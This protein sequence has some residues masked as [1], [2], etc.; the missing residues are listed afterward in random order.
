L[1]GTL[2]VLQVE[3][4]E[5]DAELIVR[6]LRR[7]GYAPEAH[8]IDTPHDLRRSLAERGW[9]LVISDYVMPSFTAL[10]ALAIV[11]ASS[12]DLPFL[13]VSGTIGEETA[14][15]ALRAGAHDFLVKGRL[16][17][18]TPAVERE[19]REAEN[20]RRKRQAEAARQASEARLRALMDA[21]AD[22]VI[23]A[24]ALGQVVETNPAAERMF[25]FS[26]EEIHGR[27]AAMLLAERLRPIYL[28]EIAGAAEGSDPRTLWQAREAVGLKRDGREFPV[29]ISLS[30]WSAGG[31]RFS[32]AI[33]RDITD[34]RHVESQ[35]LIADRM[36]AVG[37][38][39]AGVAHE[40]NNPLACVLSNLDLALMEVGDSDEFGQRIQEELRDA[41]EAADRVRH[42]VRDLK[43]FSR[44]EEDVRG[45]VDV[46]AVLESALRMA[47]NEIRHRAKVVKDYQEVPPVQANE[48]RLGQVFINLLVNAAQAIDEGSAADNEIRLTTKLVGERVVASVEDTGSGIP[49]EVRKQ[50]FVPFVTSKPAGFG[51]GLGLSICQRIVASL[52]G[53]IE[54]TSE[55]GRGSRFE[56]SLPIARQS[57]PPLSSRVSA[58]PR[59]A[60]APARILVIDDDQLVGRA[61]ERTLQPPHSVVLESAADGALDRITRGERFDL[62]LC[63][64]MMPHKSG[65]E[66]FQRLKELAPEQAAKVIFMTG[67]SFTPRA[68]AFVA[69]IATPWI[70]KPFDPSQLRELVRRRLLA[71]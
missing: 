67:G 20:R 16:A 3:D 23:T 39:A 63:D 58:A 50:L 14:V 2:R 15:D 45:P 8:R 68:R 22:A 55:V 12:L 59:L 34:R 65:I 4:S 5:E 49:P 43:V 18:L 33:V 10:E 69:A 17:R 41:R 7:G 40:I 48:G 6:E 25:G 44:N 29:E 62:V 46:R 26:R 60:E 21:A 30:T 71:E 42:I 53:A 37:T 1:K 56:V 51:T 61:V 38:L 31:E 47:R 24:D 66:L 9:D 52:G 54:V 19:L 32:A 57:A 27:P 13:I 28:A 36:V 64:L 35:L 70:E 11:R